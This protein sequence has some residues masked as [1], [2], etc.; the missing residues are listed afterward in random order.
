MLPE[1]I[2]NFIDKFSKFPSVGPRQATRLAFYIISK[3]KNEIDETI[4]SLEGL[5]KLSVCENCFFVYSPKEEEKLCNICQD[6]E[7]SSKI[8]AVVEKETD[9]ISIEK[10]KKYKGKYLVLGNLQKNGIFDSEQ[11]NKIKKTKDHIKKEFGK[12]E[13][14]IIALNPT[15]YGDF[16]ASLLINEFKDYTEKI[17]RLGRGIP[18]GGEI[19][20]ADEDTLGNAIERRI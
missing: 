15:A 8:I 9:L 2:K 3:E 1:S 14:I 5:K 11:K 19:E 17:T 16:N 6:K 7:R 10:T 12:I 18:T 13:E 20:F 4:A